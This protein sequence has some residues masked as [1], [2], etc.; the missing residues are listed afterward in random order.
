MLGLPEWY[1]NI[2]IPLMFLQSL[3]GMFIFTKK[4][5]AK[6]NFNIRVF[7]CIVVGCTALKF[8]YMNVNSANLS[9]LLML[10]GLIYLF[11][12]AT[13]K[14]CFQYSVATL[15]LVGANGYLVQHMSGCLKEIWKTLFLTECS[16]LSMLEVVL[17]DVFCCTGI[18]LLILFL[19]RP[20]EELG[21]LDIHWKITFIVLIFFFSIGV[22]RLT[23]GIHNEI[24]PSIVEN[25]YN[26]VCGY[27]FIFLQFDIA[28]RI[29]LVE[30]VVAMKHIVR[31][32]HL[33]Y[34]K[35]KENVQLI[36][37][38]YH[39][40]KSMI[41]VMKN[42]MDT[43]EMEHLEKKVLEHAPYIATGKEVL[44]VILNEKTMLC[45]KQGIQITSVISGEDLDF[46]QE[47][48][49]YALFNNSL[50]NAIDAVNKIPLQE[51]RYINLN[52]SRINDMAVIHIENPYQ[53]EL[54][55][56]AGFPK[57]NKDSRYH[58]FGMTSMEH[59]AE[60][61]G[62]SISVC[63]IENRFCLDIIL[64]EV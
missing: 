54:I 16:V 51:E 64:F 46:V 11:V 32:Q 33:Q 10:L 42:Y 14:V 29:K 3:V 4:Q 63:T 57:S 7:L 44:D 1:I 50:E 5:G 59:I 47:L 2:K 52:V 9:I 30:E 37:E 22:S 34:E 53:G 15:F 20:K 35:S 21:E 31:Q 26:I 62:G 18:C 43:K 13:A 48:D 61:Y 58:G 41:N 56:E 55:S 49:L 45:G 40:L 6:N 23:K 39:D 27:L 8:I 36:N 12:V 25:L 17:L 19:I 28:Y 24:Q 60:K 38:K